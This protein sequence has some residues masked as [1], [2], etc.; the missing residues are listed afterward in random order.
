MALGPA[1]HDAVGA[2]LHHMDVHIR[3]GLVVRGLAA[4]ALGVG[5]S[6]VHR[7]VVVLHV[8]EELLE[9]LVVVG[10]VLLI[11]L[12]GGGIDG[13]EG[14][15]AH[16]AL[17]TAGRLLTQQALHLYLFH[18]ILAGLVEVGKAVDFVAGQA[19]GGGHQVLILG[20]LG[21]RVGHGHAVDGGTDHG[22]IH[23]VVELLA[24]HVHAGVQLTQGVDVLFRGHQCHCRFLLVLNIKVPLPMF[25]NHNRT[26]NTGIRRNEVSC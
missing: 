14:V 25:S 5:H 18:Q 10:A 21:Q 6:A 17:E 22:V 4:V 2:A 8:D 26:E 20:I 1:D 16:T 9:I 15:H 23:P 19:G 3:V 13:V 11:D 12:V 24:E 7:Q